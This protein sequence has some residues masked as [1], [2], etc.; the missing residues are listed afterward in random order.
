MIGGVRS[1][2]IGVLAKVLI[3]T[4]V[5]HVMMHCFRPIKIDVLAIGCMMLRNL[6]INAYTCLALVDVG[7][8]LGS[9]FRDLVCR[10]D[11]DLRFFDTR[12]LGTC[13]PPLA[14]EISI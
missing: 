14:A 9:Q 10:L 13:R 6:R 4:W 12:C 11:L 1:I 5:C 2:K 3:I 7:S 8:M